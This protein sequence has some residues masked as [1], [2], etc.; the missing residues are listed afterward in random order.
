MGLS[1]RTARIGPGEASGVPGSI[2]PHGILFKLAAPDL[3]VAALS[4]NAAHYFGA[5]PYSLLHRRAD[6]LFDP[7]SCRRL[8]AGLADNGPGGARLV[9]I[10]L[11]KSP[12][13]VW[14]AFVHPMGAALLL[15]LKLPRPL[16]DAEMKALMQRHH[17]SSI[18]LQSA[19]TLRAVC[20]CLAR[21]IHE[22]T[23]YGRVNVSRFDAEGNR[24]VL[25]EVNKSS[26]PSCLGRHFPASDI[27]A[28]LLALYARNLECQIPDI[29]YI[30]VPLI[31]ADSEHID[32]SSSTLRAVP[33][34]HLERLRSK[35]A[36]AA[37]ALTIMSRDAPWGLIGCH[38]PYPHYVSPEVRQV[39]G[40]LAQQAS[41][42]IEG[43]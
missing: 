24:E 30:A 3:R 37:M 22:L 14:N 8:E 40:L 16:D 23:G 34:L 1:I 13:D 6:E 33:P 32:L 31:A 27:P 17:E 43:V 29:D 21:E 35:G 19:F 15:D 4:S 42:Q 9:R 36:A 7:P 38:H 10:S 2:Q 11:R 20:D 39:A 41:Q 12:S 25:A 26:L 18:R 5:D 28:E